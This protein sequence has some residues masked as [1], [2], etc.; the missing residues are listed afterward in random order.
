MYIYIYI[1]ISGKLQYPTRMGWSGPCKSQITSSGQATRWAPE[2]SC[3]TRWCAD[4]PPH[5][6]LAA[7]P[8]GDLRVAA[9]LP[10]SNGSLPPWRNFEIRPKMAS[11]TNKKGTEEIYRLKERRTGWWFDPLWKI[12]VSWDHYSQYMEK[13]KMFQTTNQKKWLDWGKSCRRHVKHFSIP[14][15][16][17]QR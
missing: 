14:L 5:E 10:Y 1:M 16:P 7:K 11:N 3:R 17:P 12:L 6:Y 9:S 2:A 15:S 4:V 8:R 13:Q